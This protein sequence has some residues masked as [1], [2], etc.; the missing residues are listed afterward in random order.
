M[1]E[2]IDG[3]DMLGVCKQLLELFLRI[4]IQRGCVQEG[5]TAVRCNGHLVCGL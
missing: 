5:F 2:D 4:K 1:T 3:G